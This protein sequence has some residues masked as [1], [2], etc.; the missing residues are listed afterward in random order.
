MAALRETPAGFERIDVALD[1][2]EQFD[3]A[4]CVAFWQAVMPAAEQKKKLF[5]SDEVLCELFERLATVEEPAKV[6]FRFVLG[7][8]LMRKRLLNYLSSRVEADRELWSMRFKG[9]EESLDMVNPKLDEA[10]LAEVSQ[11]MGQ[12]LNEEV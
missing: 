8:V 7:L 2:W 11:Q 10:A 9:R 5:V 12:I 6:N 3:R 1:A 4:G